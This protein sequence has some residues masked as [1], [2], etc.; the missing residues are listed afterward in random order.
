MKQY[1]KVL[2]MAVLVILPSLIC[3][4]GCGATNV[5]VEFGSGEYV[6]YSVKSKITEFNIC[7][8]ALDF[9]YGPSHPKSLFG[10]IGGNDAH[11]WEFVCYALYLC[12]EQYATISNEPGKYYD[13]YRTID[14]HHFIKEI[15]LEE[16]NSDAYAVTSSFLWPPKFKYHET[17]I[18]P[19]D[20]FERDSGTFAFQIAAVNQYKGS[21]GYYVAGWP[22]IYVD[23][24]YIGAQTIRLSKP[25]GR[26]W[27]Q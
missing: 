14:N 4:F 3:L 7:N 16:F 20:V 1:S 15:S 13:D 12:D 17:I 25:G 21:N 8:V 24:A 19:R 2:V 27:A 18:V 11:N 10:L 22:Y 23:Y 26:T 5:G 9:S 6:R